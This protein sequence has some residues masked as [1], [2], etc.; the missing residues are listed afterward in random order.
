MND[1]QWTPEE[2]EQVLRKAAQGI[3][4]HYWNREAR[5]KLN[6]QIVSM[7]VIWQVGEPA[8]KQQVSKRIQQYLKVHL[9][10]AFPRC[11]HDPTSKTP[12]SQPSLPKKALPTTGKGMPVGFYRV[13]EP[14]RIGSGQVQPAGST[15]TTPAHPPHPPVSALPQPVQEPPNPATLKQPLPQPAQQGP[16]NKQVCH[17]DFQ[18]ISRVTPL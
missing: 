4:D 17:K 18:E 2:H 14:P 15:P 10:K 8:S 6:E 13:E 16:P 5:E 12:S 7:L 1:G 11:Q 3:N 9:Q